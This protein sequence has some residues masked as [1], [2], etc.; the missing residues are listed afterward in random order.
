MPGICCCKEPQHGRRQEPLLAIA[1]NSCI[2]LKHTLAIAGRWRTRTVHGARRA[3]AP[4]AIRASLQDNG[5]VDSRCELHVPEVHPY[6]IRLAEHTI[7]TV[8]LVTST[9]DPT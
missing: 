1:L 5:M 6:T 8:V 3:A 2:Y 4:R 9:A 7:C